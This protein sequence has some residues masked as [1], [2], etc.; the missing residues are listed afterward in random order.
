M[1]ADICP[2]PFLETRTAAESFLGTALPH[3][4][5][6]LSVADCSIP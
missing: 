1:E 2:S 3:L 6:L 4:N 5:F